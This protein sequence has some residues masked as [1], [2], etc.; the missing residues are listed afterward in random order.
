MRGESEREYYLCAWVLGPLCWDLARLE[1]TI[2]AG[3]TPAGGGPTLPYC[4]Y[5]PGYLM[6]VKERW[7]LLR[8]AGP[9]WVPWRGVHTPHPCSYLSRSFQHAWH[10]RP[11]LHLARVIIISFFLWLLFLKEV[12]RDLPCVALPYLPTYPTTT[13][14]AAAA[15][16]TT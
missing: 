15:N 9:C 2:P 12:C 7:A 11:G 13:T 16:V 4:R 6:T 1:T 5:L 3:Y 10:V 14:A 8:S